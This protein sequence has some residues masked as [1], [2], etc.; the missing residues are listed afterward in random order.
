VSPELRERILGCTDVGR[1][2][3]WL[4]RAV[5]AASASETVDG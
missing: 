5:S 4:T 1:L 2:E 3:A